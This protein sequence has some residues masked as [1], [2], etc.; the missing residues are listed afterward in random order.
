MLLFRCVISLACFTSFA[1]SNELRPRS[2]PIAPKEDPWYTAPPNFE[3]AS[4]GT[5]LRIRKAPGNLTTIVSNSSAAYNI[6]FRSTDAR[7]RPSW[8]VTTLFVPS[9]N[10]TIGNSTSSLLSLQIPYNSADLNASPSYALY[11]AFTQPS[12]GGPSTTEDIAFMLGN[13]WFVNVPDHEGPSAS[14]GLGVQVGHAT[15]DSVRASLNSGLIPAPDTAKYAMWGYSGG[16]IA[17]EFA[18]ELQ[19]QYAPELSFLGAALGGMVPNVT[20]CFDNITASNYAGLI[21][22]GLLGITSQ[23]PRAYEYLV[24]RLKT[25]GPYNATNFLDT[26]N[27]DIATAFVVFAGQDIYEYFVGGRS[28]VYAPIIQDIFNRNSYQGYHGVPRF[29]VFVY[30]AIGDLLS[31]VKNTDEL[32]DRWCGI[33]TQVWYQ[34]N[35]VGGHTSEIVNG[36]DRALDWL[37]TVFDGTYDPPKNCL[38]ENVAVNISTTPD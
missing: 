24:S 37:K 35:T 10:V 25:S 19:E 4:P 36:H 6:L 34:R 8:A 7:Y 9:K 27:R 23:Y 12:F 20:E 13:G 28:D 5:V 30:K 16:S 31:P 38:I 17:S 2:G 14:F 11:Y 3:D 33:G 22:E 32:V 15:L 26:F 1:L 29:P 18:A 21:P